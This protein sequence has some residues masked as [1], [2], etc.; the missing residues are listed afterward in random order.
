MDADIKLRQGTIH[1]RE[2]G[3]GEPLV[4]V[5][6]LLVDGRQFVGVHVSGHH[7]AFVHHEV[8]CPIPPHQV[9]LGL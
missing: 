4:F 7:R 3:E 6:G 5:H 2:L 1:Y 8:V 9:A